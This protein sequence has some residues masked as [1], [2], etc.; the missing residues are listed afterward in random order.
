M[1]WECTRADGGSATLTTT[2]YQTKPPMVLV[3]H[4]NQTRPAFRVVSADGAKYEGQD[5]MFWEARG[6]AMSTWSG[7]SLHCKPSARD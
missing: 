4:D 7:V 1:E 5:V 6:E 3:E 2:Y